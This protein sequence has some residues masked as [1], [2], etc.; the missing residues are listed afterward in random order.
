MFVSKI[1]LLHLFLHHSFFPW[2]TLMIVKELLL[3]LKRINL[4]HAHWLGAI[5]LIGEASAPYEK[6]FPFFFFPRRGPSL[7]KY[8]TPFSPSP[9][10]RS[11]LCRDQQ[12]VA[13]PD[14]EM[15][16]HIWNLNIFITDILRPVNSALDHILLG[17]R[18]CSWLYRKWEL[19]QRI[20]DKTQ[21]GTSGTSR[22]CATCKRLFT[23]HTKY[24]FIVPSITLTT[25][26]KIHHIQL[27]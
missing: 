13:K 5:T 9:Q 2:W 19:S 10:E 1:D 14:T 22:H 26:L 24:T 16:K 6:Y 4:L 11:Q 15:L 12:I 25:E 7:W 20:T 18:S 27:Q 21:C 17:S 8:T 3:F 23:N